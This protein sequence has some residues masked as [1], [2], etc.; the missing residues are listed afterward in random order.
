MAKQG[1]L[2]VVD[3]NVNIL[4]SLKYLL[5][6]YFAQVVTLSSPVTIPSVL[7]E[8]AP[9]VVLLDMNFSSGINSGNEGL[10][11]LREIRRLRPQ[12]QVV[13]FT[14]YADISLAVTGIKEGASD[15]VVKPWDNARLVQTLQEAYA[16]TTAK[17]KRK[18]AVSQEP[19]SGM[20]WGKFFGDTSAEA[21]GREGKR[22]GCQ[23]PDNG[24]ERNGQ[25]HA[26]PGDSSPVEPARWPARIGG[27][28]RHNRVFV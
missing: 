21:S 16:K 25:G 4:T 18:T 11:W 1:T 28:G 8:R 17:G 5:G 24:R 23:Y 20:Y 22:H 19:E 14:A 3:D 26:G 7:R 6:E 13:L 27:Y 9:D 15:F 10:Y 2:L 12:T